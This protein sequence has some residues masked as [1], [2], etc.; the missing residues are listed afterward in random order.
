[1]Y[2]YPFANI[3]K[4]HTVLSSYI[5]WGDILNNIIA[6]YHVNGGYNISDLLTKHWIYSN[7]WKPLNTIMSCM[8]DTMDFL[9]PE[10]M[11]HD[12]RS[13]G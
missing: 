4:H 1:M 9:D 13:K 11:D 3:H 7:V 2:T 6:L 8:G 5:F 10:S 12:G